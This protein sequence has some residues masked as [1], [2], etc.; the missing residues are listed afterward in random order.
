LIVRDENGDFH[1]NGTFR[2]ARDVQ[3]A[4]DQL[5]QQEAYAN[6]VAADGKKILEV[7]ESVF[8]HS[9]FTG[10]SGTFFAYEGLGSIYWHMVTKL[11][12]AVQE[13]YLLA[14]QQSA[15]QATVQALAEHYYD[16]RQG[17]G[18][19]K[20]PDV[21]GGFPTDPYS[22]TPAG[23][24]AKQP[25]MTGQVKE[26]ILTRQAELG[27]FVRNGQIVFDPTLLRKNEFIVQSAV[28]EYVDLSGKT[29]SID[30]PAGSLAYTF[31]Q[32]LIVYHA[33]DKTGIKVYFSDGR[34]VEISG[35]QLDFETSQHVFKRDG[36]VRNLVVSVAGV[37]HPARSATARNL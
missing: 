16:I 21:Y 4:L 25:G 1:F 20:S 30:L 28:F 10:R 18:F 17:L 24:G 6:L 35:N 12:L 9:S 5:A 36:L 22:H 11:L 19:N 34:V 3:Q 8:D 15:D 14:L 27:L 13:N 32:T 23:Q 26:E 7:F 33:S 2:N 31:C 29:Q 37:P